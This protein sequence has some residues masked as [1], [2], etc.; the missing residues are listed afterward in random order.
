MRHLKRLHQAVLS[1]A[2][3]RRAGATI[4]AAVQLAVM[5][6]APIAGGVG[7]GFIN[8]LKNNLMYPPGAQTIVP[9]VATT[10]ITGAAIDFDGADGPCFGLL[11]VGAVSGTTPTLDVKYQECD[12][13]GGTY[14]DI[15]GATHAQ[16]T[17]SSKTTRIN[18]R[19]SKRWVK[20][21]GTIAGTT[22]SFAF[23]VVVEATK[24]IT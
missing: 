2:S 6:I 16:V 8:D 4:L 5:G 10:T 19:R 13:S 14:A 21:I 23:A 11:V 3:H 24:R 12:T 18:F 7:G 1:F 20:A 22:P 17:A 15:T 9:Q